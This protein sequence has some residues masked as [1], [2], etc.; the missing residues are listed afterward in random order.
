MIARRRFNH[1]TAGLLSR[2]LSRNNDVDGYW[3]LGVLFT[4]AH[5][6]YKQVEIDILHGRA[7][8]DLPACMQVARHWVPQ[9][10]AAL[11]RHGIAPAVLEAATVSIEFGLAPMPKLPGYPSHHHYGPDFLCTLRLQARDG[12]VFARQDRGY[13]TPHEQFPGRRSTRRAG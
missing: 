1:I 9:L 13:C 7:R 10:R 12:R 4:E 3:A 5:A 6:F 11:D 2:F 8:P